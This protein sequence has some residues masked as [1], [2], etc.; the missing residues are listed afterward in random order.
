VRWL[1][2]IVVASFAVSLWA[3]ARTPSA[4]F[5]LL[6]ARAWELLLGALVA[7][8]AFPA[9]RARAA[10]EVAAGAG[11]LLI[12]GGVFAFDQ[13]TPFPG[14]AALAP[15]VGTALVIHAG[16]GGASLVSRLLSAPQAVFVGKMS[17]SLY[18]WHWPA[19]VFAR[20]YKQAPLAPGETLALVAFSFLCAW[21]SLR[22]VEQ[23]FRKPAPG[24][25]RRRL[26]AGAGVA[27]AVAVVAGLAGHLTGGWPA[28]WP[29][30][31]P[32]PVAGRERYR[33]GA[34]FLREDQPARAW[35]GLPACL[36]DAGAPR[37]VLL[38]GDSF[39]AHLIPG[40]E[41]RGWPGANVALYTMSGC[42]PVFGVPTPARPACPEFTARVEEVLAR[43]GAD[44]VVLSARWEKYWDAGLDAA[45]LQ[46]TVDRLTARGLRVVL[47]GQGPTFE[48]EQAYDW[49][50]RQR[51]DLAPPRRFESLNASLAALRGV[52]LFFDPHEASCRGGRCEVRRD[53][54][55]LY[56]DWGHLSAAGSG[57]LVAALAA[58]A[59]P[60]APAVPAAARAPAGAP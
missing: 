9:L 45:K 15:V 44:T 13:H 57:G 59:G 56:V 55:L 3:T 51:A 25:S 19:L 38:W 43:S 20:H 5:Y 46:A 33:E 2:P 52:E 22:F 16:E 14:V 8:R 30:Y 6:H 27:M 54:Q 7:L 37:T 24:A 58:R 35:A 60:P 17:Y 10:R 36:L 41:D 18:L 11:F 29:G 40:L 26:F 48:F 31:A 12:L 42:P 47:V 23:P 39:G 4:A 21:L 32:P 1:V 28:R 50:Y 34:C 49:V 53:G